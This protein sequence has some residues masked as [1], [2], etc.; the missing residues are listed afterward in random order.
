MIILNIYV[1]LKTKKYIYAKDSVPRKKKEYAVV[2]GAGLTKDKKPSCV[3]SDRLDGAI[4]LFEKGLVDKILV[5]GDHRGD[6]YSETEAMAEYLKS[7]G[8]ASDNIL[9]D[10]YGFSTFETVFNSIKNYNAKSAYYL[11]QG[12]HLPRLIYS[13]R[14]L[15]CDASG[16]ICDFH[17]YSKKKHRRWKLREIPSRFKD[18][19]LATYCILAKKI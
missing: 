13:A 8:I 19:F 5:S 2:P 3:L 11:S 12:F 4:A 17:K 16:I 1:I 6:T 14:K 9:M 18:F 15:K 7:K 10:N